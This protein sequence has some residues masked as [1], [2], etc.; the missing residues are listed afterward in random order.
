MAVISARVHPG[1]SNASWMMQGLLEAVTAD[2]EQARQLRRSL[3]L[4]IVPMLNPDGVILGENAM[5]LL[6][7]M[8]MSTTPM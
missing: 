1:E 2:T 6:A 4:K 7:A 3:I 5:P 8:S